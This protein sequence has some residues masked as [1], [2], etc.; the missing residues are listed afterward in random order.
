MV[1]PTI[2]I[3]NLIWS[4]D[5]T[6]HHV[7]LLLLNRDHDPF[8]G[9]WALPETLMRPDESADTAALRLVREK[10]GLVLD[11][12]HT[13]Q[14]A[15]FTHPDRTPTHRRVALAYMTFL[16]KMPPLTPGYGAQDA[17]WFQV[18]ATKTA[19]QVQNGNTRF[20][21]PT[22]NQ[23]ATYYADLT[24]RHAAPPSQLAFDHDWLLAV[25]ARRIRHELAFHPTVFLTLGP[26]F[27][28]KEARTVAATFLRQPLSALDNSNFK[29]AHRDHFT[30]VG[31]TATAHAGRPATLYRLN[32]SCLTN[33]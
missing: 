16:P 14:L 6:T 33:G 25:A 32:S 3:T 8:N 7:N 15:T 29:K 1:S 20:T 22:T 27:T 31:T 26:T 12:Q 30:A 4:F 11:G 24:T 17:R 21:T 5:R 10:I 2:T 19:Y 23:T 18:T 9:F 13:Q 28:L